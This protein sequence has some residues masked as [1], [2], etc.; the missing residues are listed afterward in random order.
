MK[1]I[2]HINDILKDRGITQAELARR[3]GLT[4]AAVS[5]LASGKRSGNLISAIKIAN[6]LGLS[7]SEIWEI[8]EE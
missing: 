8:K 7:L 4:V 6:E 1:L 5:L 3:T 2:C